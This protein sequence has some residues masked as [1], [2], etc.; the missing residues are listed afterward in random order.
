VVRDDDHRVVLVIERLIILVAVAAFVAWPSR[1]KNG[2]GW[3]DTRTA[4]PHNVAKNDVASRATEAQGDVRVNTWRKE[5]GR[6]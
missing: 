6:C 1:R 2:A 4:K 5:A 3:P